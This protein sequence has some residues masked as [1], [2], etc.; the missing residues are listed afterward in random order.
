MARPITRGDRALGLLCNENLFETMDS[1]P[2]RK[3]IIC[4]YYN[5][6]NSNTSRV[7]VCVCV[8]CMCACYEGGY[9]KILLS[10]DGTLYIDRRRQKI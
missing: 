8:V 9:V 10:I 3:H 4:I 7:C 6:N 1:R 2:Y 5:N